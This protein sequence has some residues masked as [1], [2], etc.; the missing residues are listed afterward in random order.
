MDY[1]IFH[2]LLVNLCRFNSFKQKEIT[3]CN[4][5][6]FRYSS[7][8]ILILTL[9]SRKMKMAAFTCPRAGADLWT[10]MH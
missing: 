3:H 2:V 8:A 10:L 1:I 6:F 5:I 7:P 9:L 4:S